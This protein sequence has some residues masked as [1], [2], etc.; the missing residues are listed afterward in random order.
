MDFVLQPGDRTKILKPK[1][2][3]DA[4]VLPLMLGF[5]VHPDY[6]EVGIPDPTF[7][8]WPEMAI[9]PHWSLLA[10]PDAAV[11]WADKR[12]AAFW[13]GGSSRRFGGKTRKQLVGCRDEGATGAWVADRLDIKDAS[14]IGPRLTTKG[15]AG[16][17]AEGS[18]GGL[19]KGSA[20]SSTGG[21]EKPESSPGLPSPSPGSERAGSGGE[22]ACTSSAC[23]EWV[24]PMAMCRNK[25]AIFAQ[26]EGSAR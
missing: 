9:P 6:L 13:R 8:A 18:V 4:K 14:R 12:D 22:A 19:V 15:S 11:P 23:A 7:W 21:S 5:A 1:H 26:G 10:S 2:P 3:L 17:S 24:G 25:I 20:K 16:G